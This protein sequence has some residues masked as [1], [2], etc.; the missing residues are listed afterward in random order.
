MRAPR[1]QGAAPLCLRTAALKRSAAQGRRRQCATGEG[2][3]RYCGFDCVL[4]L[5]IFGPN[6]VSLP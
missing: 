2:C 3:F 1:R 4:T 5:V 6:K